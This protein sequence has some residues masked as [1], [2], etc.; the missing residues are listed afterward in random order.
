ME[1]EVKFSELVRLLEKNGFKIIKEKGSIRYYEKPGCDYS[2]RLKSGAS[3][4]FQPRDCSPNLN[5]L[6]TMFYIAQDCGNN[7]IH[8][9]RTINNNSILGA[10][11]K[12]PFI[13]AVKT[14]GFLVI[15]I[16]KI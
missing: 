5:I 16:V 7:L 13:P 10:E 6:P 11:N 4:D 2:L 12:R 1:Y 3:R 15:N 9:Q 8:C 14:E